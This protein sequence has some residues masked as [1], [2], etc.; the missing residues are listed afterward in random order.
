AR[1]L[2][3]RLRDPAALPPHRSR[4]VQHIA[5]ARHADGAAEHAFAPDQGLD[6]RAD[7]WLEPRPR[8][9]PRKLPL[10]MLHGAPSSA[11]HRDD[12]EE[13]LWR[14]LRQAGSVA[15]RERLFTFYLPFAR[16]LA[17]RKFK[18]HGAGDIEY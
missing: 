11:G 1:G 17:G 16:A 2:Q 14:A 12:E 4:G 6:V 3:N 8:R 18:S 5:R 10:K 13:L 9:R 15:A 7:R